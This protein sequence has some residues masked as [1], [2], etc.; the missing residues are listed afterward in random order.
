MQEEAAVSTNEE[1]SS[2]AAGALGL[3]CSFCGKSQAQVEKLIAG[4]GVYICDECVGLCN[5]V[6]EAEAVEVPNASVEQAVDVL[7]KTDATDA[8]TR[9]WVA[10]CLRLGAT[11]AQ[12][13]EV[14]GMS[15]TD[16]ERQLGPND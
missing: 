2:A 14:M 10:L 7:N 11:W 9:S 8:P 5:T 3:D 16:A 13:G 1:G 6:L 12:I 15:A 4:P